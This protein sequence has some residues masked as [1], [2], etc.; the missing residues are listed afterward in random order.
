MDADRIIGKL[1]EKCGYVSG[2]IEEAVKLICGEHNST[3]LDSCR[4]GIPISGDDAPT[5]ETDETKADVGP[6][7]MSHRLLDVEVARCSKVVL[8]FMRH[9]ISADMPQKVRELRAKF[10]DVLAVLEIEELRYVQQFYAEL[11][12]ATSYDGSM[13][14]IQKCRTQMSGTKI[15][16]DEFEKMIGEIKGV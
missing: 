8:V 1:K 4:T 11:I 12:V 10:G 7:E 9:I 2:E 6:I 15:S 16:W 14:C 13:L 3:G 5:K